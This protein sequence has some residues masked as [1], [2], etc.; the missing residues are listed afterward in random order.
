[1]GEVF[2]PTLD[3]AKGLIPNID[4]GF[5]ASL[6]KDV[7][8]VESPIY[9]PYGLHHDYKARGYIIPEA[10]A[11]VDVN[12]YSGISIVPEEKYD[13]LSMF[14]TPVM[15]SFWVEG[16]SYKVFDECTG[17]LIDRRY[18]DFEF[19]VATIVSLR[20]PKNIIK[21]SMRGGYGTVKEIYGFDDWEIQI[22]GI[23][24]DDPSRKGQKTKD[25]QMDALQRIDEIAGSVSILKGSI[26]LNRKISRITLEEGISFNPIQGKPNIMPFSIKAC[27]D[28]D[29]LLTG[30]L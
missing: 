1:M 7:Y 19:P 23:I 20:R 17:Q 18:D 9:L 15:G 14:G 11:N 22:D 28:D 24:F 27:S 16:G 13:R 2:I 25:E 12:G 5:A 6:L 8:G 29:I 3:K 10:S 21:T 4:I 30:L 26:F